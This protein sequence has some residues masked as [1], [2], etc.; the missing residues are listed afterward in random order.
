MPYI[1]INTK[2][3]NDLN[4]GAKIIKLIEENLGIHLHDFR[5]SNGLILGY[6]T[7]SMNHNNNNNNNWTSS[8]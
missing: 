2:W 1:G 6:N 8:K 3:I 4:I 5:F 7:K